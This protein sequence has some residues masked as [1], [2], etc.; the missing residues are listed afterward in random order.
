MMKLTI[1]LLTL[2]IT[3]AIACNN[4]ADCSFNGFCESNNCYCFDNYVTYDSTVPCNYK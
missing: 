2:S 4:T 3:N 1:I